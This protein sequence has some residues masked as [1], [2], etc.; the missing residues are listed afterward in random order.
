MLLYERTC[1]DHNY[2]ELLSPQVPCDWLL[3]HNT[4]KH[5]LG[6]QFSE[7]MNSE[8]WERFRLPSCVGETA[9]NLIKNECEWNLSARRKKWTIFPCMRRIQNV[10]RTYIIICGSSVDWID[11]GR[12]GSENTAAAAQ[13][14]VQIHFLAHFSVGIDALSIPLSS[15]S[16]WASITH[17]CGI[18]FLLQLVLLILWLSVRFFCSPATCAMQASNDTR[19]KYIMH[20]LNWRKPVGTRVVDTSL[21]FK[22]CERGK[23]TWQKTNNHIGANH[24][25]LDGFRCSPFHTAY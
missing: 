15:W 21:T 16:M 19:K 5:T 20:S 4:A 22:S 25:C 18:V 14:I 8:N 23:H 3:S 17:F 9:F 13:K 7:R 6:T 11:K 12:E 10:F 2:F 1:V 24:I